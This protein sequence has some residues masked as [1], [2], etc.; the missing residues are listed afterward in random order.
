MDYFQYRDGALWCEDVAVA[1]IAAAAGTPLYVYSA[2]TLREHYARFAEAFAELKP[3]VCFS[4]KALANVHV[5]KL[6]AA[7][8][9]GFD[10]V[11]GG[12][13]ARALAAGADPAKIAF[14]GVAKTDREIT[15]AIAVG[16]GLFNVESEGELANLSRLAAEAGRPVR[17]GVRINPDVYDPKTHAKTTTGRR[18]TKFGVDIDRAARLFESHAGDEALCLDT[19]DMHLGSP[20]YSAGPYVRA[21]EKALALVADLAA[22]GV[23]IRAID[24]GGGFGAD[25]E[26]GAT[27]LA[28]EYAKSIVPL[29]R[30]AGLEVILE[31]GRQIAANAGLLL[32]RVE[33]VKSGGER[34]FVIVDAAMTDLIRPALY[35][36]RHFVYPVVLPRGADPPERRIDYRPDGGTN[37]DVVGGVCETADFLAKDRLLPPL[38][39]G[40]LLAV[41]SAGAYGFVMSSQYNSRPRAAEVLV[42]GGRWRLI[43]RRETYDDLFAAELDV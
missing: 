1:D 10:V 5:L 36:A 27:P 6:L 38:A 15:E 33:Y 8:G 24:L 43:R 25:Y 42:E 41:F 37:V 26:Q 4:I 40:D 14:A 22:R 23:T 7:E 32:T 31:P 3:T 39:R 12:E 28:A 35:D 30:P 29:L 2:R 18:G 13:L 11:S 21:I 34:R 19:I 20:I 17:A 9:C 16:V